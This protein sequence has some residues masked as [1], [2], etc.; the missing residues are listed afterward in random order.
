MER[1]TTYRAWAHK[2]GAYLHNGDHFESCLGLEMESFK[3]YYP[4]EWEILNSAKRTE[5]GYDALYTIFHQELELHIIFTKSLLLF[6]VIKPG[7]FYS[8]TKAG[9]ALIELL[10]FADLRFILYKRVWLKKGNIFLDLSVCHCDSEDE[11]H[12]DLVTGTLQTLE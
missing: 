8:K 11:L 2:G 9:K 12:N 6:D 3:K 1:Q 7:C 5:S 10:E 4:K